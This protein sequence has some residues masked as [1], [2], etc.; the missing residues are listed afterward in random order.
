MPEHEL[1]RLASI[2]TKRLTDKGIDLYVSKNMEEFELTMGK[3]DKPA[4]HPMI[5]VTHHDLSPTNSFGLLCKK[6]GRVFAGTAARFLDI[7]SMPLSYHLQSSYKRFYGSNTQ[8]PVHQFTKAAATDISGQIV[9][10]GE[11]FIDRKD[12]GDP[13]V[14]RCILHYILV[15]SALKWKPTWFYGFMSAANALKGRATQYGFTRQYPGAQIWKTE[16]NRRSTGEYLIA[17][18]FDELV[19]TAKFF[20]TEEDRFPIS[21]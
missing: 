1:I 2:C 16:G 18:T 21:K 4:S 13:D 8:S 14:A 20:A 17:L 12:R 7:G 10:L 9:Y 11:L 3:L 5:A 15:L 19:S 6:D